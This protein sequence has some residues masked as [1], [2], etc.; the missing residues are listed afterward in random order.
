M[1][2]Q[3]IGL[4]FVAI[5]TFR[6]VTLAKHSCRKALRWSVV[7]KGM[8][9]DTSFPVCSLRRTCSLCSGDR[10]SVILPIPT[11]SSSSSCLQN[12]AANKQWKGVSMDLSTIVSL[13]S[14]CPTSTLRKK[15][16]LFG[17]FET[18][19]GRNDCVVVSSLKK[20]L[21]VRIAF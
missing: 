19:L 20:T 9:A 5:F 2:R 12:N 4:R 14:F 3:S 15:A 13:Q 6:C 7:S 21:K 16:Q 18:I 11:R 17:S 8:L 10:I 1:S